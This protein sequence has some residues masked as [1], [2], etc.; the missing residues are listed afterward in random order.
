MCMMTAA[1]ACFQK[2]TGIA[3]WSQ[4]QTCQELEKLTN[5]P[6]SPYPIKEKAHQQSFAK[7]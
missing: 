6:S 7:L 2:S 4:T 3:A 1:S 5:F